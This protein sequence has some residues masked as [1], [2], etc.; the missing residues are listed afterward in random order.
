MA[1]PVINQDL[2]A[3]LGPQG[4]RPELGGALGA[5]RS[6]PAEARGPS[7]AD[8]LKDAIG[9]VNRLQ[10]EADSSIEKLVTGEQPDVHGTMIALEKADLSFRMMMEVRNKL[11][12]A[13]QEVMRMG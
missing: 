8:T 1:D 13:Y 11:L 12:D 2:R 9:Q 7:F 10:S 6:L 5:A 3:L 4:P